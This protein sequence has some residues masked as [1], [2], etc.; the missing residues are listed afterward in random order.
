M[1]RRAELI[2]FYASELREK[3]GIEPDAELLE[4]VTLGCGPLIY[5]AKTAVIDPDSSADI[6]QV[7]ENF[8]IRKLALRDGPELTEAIDAAFAAY[9][10]KKTPKHRAVVYYLLARHFRREDQVRAAAP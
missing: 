9:G 8:L 5:N 3:C 7:R 2:D 1:G 10:V 6:A 4:A